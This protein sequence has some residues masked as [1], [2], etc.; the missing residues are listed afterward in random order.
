MSS[1]DCF[2]LILIK[3]CEGFKRFKLDTFSIKYLQQKS[4]YTVG[5]S[6]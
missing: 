5:T 2:N 4:V 3:N 1:F 6:K